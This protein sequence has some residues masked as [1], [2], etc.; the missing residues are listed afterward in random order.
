[1]LEHVGPHRGREGRPTPQPP[2]IFDGDDE[3]SYSP[4]NAERL[5]K[6]IEWI[7]MR[8]IE[9]AKNLENFREKAREA[10]EGN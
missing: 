6:E 9:E 2:G 7:R 1:M 10:T 8:I 5:L 4:E 3:L